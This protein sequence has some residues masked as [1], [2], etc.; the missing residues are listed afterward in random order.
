MKF[1]LQWR[2]ILASLLD[3]GFFYLIGSLIVI[4]FMHE[5]Q[6]TRSIFMGTDAGVN[7][8]FLIAGI[9]ALAWVFYYTVYIPFHFF[10]GQ[11]LMQKLFGVGVEFQNKKLMT[12]RSLFF[13]HGFFGIVLPIALINAF[14][15]IIGYLAFPATFAIIIIANVICSIFFKFDATIA[16]KSVKIRFYLTSEKKVI[17]Y[18]KH[19][20]EKRNN[21]VHSKKKKRSNK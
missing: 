14:L 12:Y 16:E 9:S 2:F 20:I 8:R 4:G 21:I 1:K 15:P 19:T 6:V 10:N 17:N 7:G 3:V 11:T 13:L 18:T 5:S